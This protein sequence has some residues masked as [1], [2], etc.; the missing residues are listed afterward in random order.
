M[1]I[2]ILSILLVFAG[3]SFAQQAKDSVAIAHSIIDDYKTLGNW[4]IQ[5]HIQDCTADYILIENGEIMTLNDE[6]NYY[7][8]N[9]ARVITRTDSFEFNSIRIIGDIG[10]AV[11]TLRSTIVENGVTNTR[12]WTE[13]IICKRVKSEWKIA[14]IHSTP[15]K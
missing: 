8:K 4:D 9:A 10:Y 2:F 11:Y 12:K 7:K 13:S 1:K 15:I 3:D 14:L 5:K 6:I